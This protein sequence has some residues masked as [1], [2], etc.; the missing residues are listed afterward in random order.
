M[1]HTYIS[2]HRMFSS[3]IVDVR[4]I[5]LARWVGK[6]KGFKGPPIGIH[7]LG[8]GIFFDLAHSLSRPFIS[9]FHTCSNPLN[10]TQKKK[11]K[12]PFPN[13]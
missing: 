3:G 7:C 9:I 13:R 8:S 6:K 11:T 4:I 1:I 12:T 5:M 10:P 2:Y